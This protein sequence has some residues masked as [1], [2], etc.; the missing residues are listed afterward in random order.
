MISLSLAGVAWLHRVVPVSADG[1]LGFAGFALPTY[2]ALPFDVAVIVAPAEA[3]GD[4]S[5]IAA[6]AGEA[7]FAIV[8]D[9]GTPLPCHQMMEF[10]PSFQ[11]QTL[12]KTAFYVSQ[13]GSDDR[14]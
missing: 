11:G 4:A 2:D 13:N 9:A 1:V 5:S 10:Y 3:G 8:F 14:G 7:D 6:A 12:H